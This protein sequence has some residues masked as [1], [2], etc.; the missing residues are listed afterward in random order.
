MSLLCSE[1]FHTQKSRNMSDDC[2]ATGSPSA[3][4]SS[5][6]LLLVLDAINI[7]L[8]NLF[9]ILTQPVIQIIAHISLHR[10]LFSSTRRLR[11]RAS[12]CELLSQLLC[13]LLKI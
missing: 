9:M 1:C 6:F 3:K 8:R 7:V 12:S 2:R 5:T 4:S 13:Y 10:N 11:D